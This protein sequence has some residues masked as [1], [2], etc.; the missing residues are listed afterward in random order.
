MSVVSLA[1]DS[2][3]VFL[4][5]KFFPAGNGKRPEKRPINEMGVPTSFTSAEYTIADARAIAN[6]NDG[7]IGVRCD[8]MRDP[9]TGE[10]YEQELFVVDD[11]SENAVNRNLFTAF[12]DR[13]AVEVSPSGSGIHY[14]FYMTPTERDLLY[15]QIGTDDKV[16]KLHWRN[17]A[18]DLFPGGSSAY[19][20][21]T[22]NYQHFPACGVGYLSAAEASTVLLPLYT[23]EMEARHQSTP[24]A[25]ASTVHIG[26]CEFVPVSQEVLLAIGHTY[27]GS[28]QQFMTARRQID[29]DRHD[30]N[31]TAIYAKAFKKSRPSPS[32]VRMSICR[33]LFY[34]YGARPIVIDIM[35][36]IFPLDHDTIT[37]YNKIVDSRCQELLED[38]PSYRGINAQERAFT[39]SAIKQGVSPHTAYNILVGSGMASTLNLSLEYGDSNVNSPSL[40]TVIKGLL[41]E[42]GRSRFH[43]MCSFEEI[44]LMWGDRFPCLKTCTLKEFRD[45]AKND[46]NISCERCKRRNSDKVTRWDCII[47]PNYQNK[48]KEKWI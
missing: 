42:L 4:A 38:K 24:S 2:R 47:H 23:Q 28:M 33:E 29:T 5:W 9:S 16:H 7:G 11:D 40:K 27:D 46:L 35:N 41:T 45:I 44:Q 15:K 30:A 17:I 12:A 48:L 10:C 21:V 19:I 26:Q 22:E 32:E 36:S 37:V 18:L 6:N 8:I 31:V 43:D 14:Y 3:L 20:T 25:S 13:V 34:Y 1:E 39:I